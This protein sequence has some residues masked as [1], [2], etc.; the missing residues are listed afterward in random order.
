M[1]IMMTI[2]LRVEVTK[3]CVIL[4]MYQHH[5]SNILYTCCFATGRGVGVGDLMLVCVVMFL[6]YFSLPSLV[7]FCEYSS[8]SC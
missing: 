1:M 4:S 5:Q 6:G 3:S 8:L 7:D 2:A